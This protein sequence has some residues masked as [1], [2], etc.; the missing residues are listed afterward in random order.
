MYLP[1]IQGQTFHHFP[2]VV[3]E[4]EQVFL[5]AGVGLFICILNAPAKQFRKGREGD[6]Q[7]M[8]IPTWQCMEG[9]SKHPFKLKA[10]PAFAHVST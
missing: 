8:F 7:A 10:M 3:E 1:G 5:P 6:R 9:V 4:R 2:R